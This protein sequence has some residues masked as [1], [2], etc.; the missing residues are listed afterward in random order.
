[1]SVF[2]FSFFEDECA[3]CDI[4]EKSKE[5]KIRVGT[6]AMLLSQILR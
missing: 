1:M 4:F 6:V 3:A 2:L 5:E